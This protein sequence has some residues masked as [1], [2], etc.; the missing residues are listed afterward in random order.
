M[1]N[2]K[3]QE[4]VT[5]L[6]ICATPTVDRSQALLDFKPWYIPKIGKIIGHWMEDIHKAGSCKSEYIFSL[7][8]EGE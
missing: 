5:E 3:S 8:A 2:M 6:L 1:V 7:T 4:R